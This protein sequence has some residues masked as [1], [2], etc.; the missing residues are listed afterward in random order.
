MRPTINRTAGDRAQRAVGLGANATPSIPTITETNVHSG[1]FLGADS[2]VWDRTTNHYMSGIMVS[3]KSQDRRLG[4]GRQTAW[5]IIPLK[6]T[7]AAFVGIV[8]APDQNAALKAAIEQLGVA[9]EHRHRL[10]V[11]RQA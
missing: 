6:G 9:S 2:H 4:A 7:P 10:L 3:R 1:K 8:Y 11:R 5:E